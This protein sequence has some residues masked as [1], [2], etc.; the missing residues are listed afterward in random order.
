SAIAAAAAASA[1]GDCGAPSGTGFR[2]VISTGIGVLARAITVY[3]PGETP[4]KEN[5]PSPPVRVE[6]VNRPGIVGLDSSNVTVALQA[7]P[8]EPTTTPDTLPV[9][10]ICS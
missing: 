1:A 2:T 4:V 10:T 6:R 7:G 9:G 5:A 3:D 8:P